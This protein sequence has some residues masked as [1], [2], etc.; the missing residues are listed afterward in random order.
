MVTYGRRGGTIL[1]AG[2]ERMV[3]TRFMELNEMAP[4]VFI[5]E[6]SII[7]DYAGVVLG[8]EVGCRVGVICLNDNMR[9]LHVDNETHVKVVFSRKNYW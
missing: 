6:A 3:Y 5:E 8:C 9:G 2:Y 1:F 4:K 7:T